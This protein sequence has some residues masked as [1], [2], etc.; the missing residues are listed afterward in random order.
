MTR[1]L[2]TGSKTNCLGYDY[3][4]DS[5]T[6]EELAVQR[7][8][9]EVSQAIRVTIPEGSFIITPEAREAAKKRREQQL[10][11]FSEKQIPKILGRFYCLALDNHFEKLSPIAVAR[12][13]YL[14]TFIKYGTDR[15]YLTERTPLTKKLL[16]EVMGVSE[17]TV[18][19]F[20]EE[21][22]EYIF[23]DEEHNLHIQNPT[24]IR[25]KL[26]S[27]NG[28]YQKI[29]IDAA[30]KLYTETPVKNHKQLGYIF[31]MLPFISIEHSILCHRPFAK[32]VKDIQPMTLKEFCEAVGLAY[33]RTTISRLKK[34]Y[35]DI[36]FMVHGFP[37]LFC[38]FVSDGQN[39]DR[40]RIIVNPR[41]LYS[42]RDPEQ[43]RNLLQLMP[44]PQ[45]NASV[46]TLRKDKKTPKSYNNAGNGVFPS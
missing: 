6:G 21:V 32:D 20:L 34:G 10:E 36:Q 35:S 43:V 25:G 38:A 11:Y 19:R 24:F 31:L 5:E 37:E 22:Q 27:E 13:V 15:L 7:A 29:Y 17:D 42:G 33:N 44:K 14:G 18:S 39:H 12:L 30:R 46:T 16:P 1:I 9:G 28:G 41:I 8:T 4:V 23:E 26:P 45:S 2:Q 3:I 40:D